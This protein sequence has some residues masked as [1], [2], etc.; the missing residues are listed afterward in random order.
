MALPLLIF[1]VSA[2]DS[3]GSNG[4]NGSGNGNGQTPSGGTAPEFNDGNIAFENNVF[5]DFGAGDSFSDVAKAGD[6]NLSD[7]EVAGALENGFKN[8]SSSFS[9][10]DIGTDPGITAARTPDGSLDPVPSNTGNLPDFLNASEFADGQNSSDGPVGVTP[11]QNANLDFI[12]A[13]DPNASNPWIDGWTALDDYGYLSGTNS[14]S[15]PSTEVT[16]TDDITSDRTL[17][18]DTRYIVDGLLFVGEPTNDGIPT[19]NEPTLTIEPGT[20]IKFK[21]SGAVTA[22]GETGQTEGASALIVRRSGKIEAN[23]TAAEPIIMTSTEDDLTDP[24]DMITGA[25]VPLREEWGGVIILGEA[26]NNQPTQDENQI[27]GIPQDNNP[28][29]YGG[30]DAGDD[31]G[32]FKYVSI[33]HAGISI[34]G[35]A[36]DEIN[37]LTMGS[38][39]DQTEIHHVEV[40]ANFDDGFEWFG[41]TVDTHHLAAA[42]VGDDAFDYDVGFQATGYQ[43]FALSGTDRAGRGGEHDNVGSSGPDAEPQSKPVISNVTYIGSG[44]SATPGGDGNDIAV[45]IRDGGAG[46]YYNSIFTQYPDLAVNLGE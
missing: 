44:T 30:S 6:P 4:G 23:G 33:R 43:W 39:G 40:F 32:T 3:G 38:L 13:F 14:R 34:S 27:E 31:S 22:T 46:E 37:G 21:G 20:V 8:A 29:L 25:G 5:Y 45:F 15:E 24:D 16:L 17:K 26:P 10:N 12:G 19:N 2:C 41:G 11:I 42:F 7:S 1:T 35:V 28:A 9:G 18:S 36:G